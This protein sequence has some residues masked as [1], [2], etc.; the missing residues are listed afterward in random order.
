MTAQILFKFRSNFCGVSWSPSSTYYAPGLLE[1]FVTFIFIAITLF[2][3]EHTF[4]TFI[5][6]DK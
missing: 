2:L 6:L 3:Q 1:V 4:E 5:S